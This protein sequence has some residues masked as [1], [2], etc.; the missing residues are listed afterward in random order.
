MPI[1]VKRNPKEPIQSLVY[2]F[3]KAVRAS[4]TLATLRKRRFRIRQ[5]SRTLKRLAALRREE[6]KKRR[7]REAKMGKPSR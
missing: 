3:S 1:E 6:I 7:I 4:S 5:K 2:R